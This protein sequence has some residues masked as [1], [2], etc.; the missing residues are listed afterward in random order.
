MVGFFLEGTEAVILS[1]ECPE[2]GAYHAQMHVPD[3]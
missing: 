2:A 3:V 1:N